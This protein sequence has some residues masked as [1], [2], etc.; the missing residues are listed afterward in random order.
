MTFN[1]KITKKVKDTLRNLIR[2]EFSSIIREDQSY[3]GWTNYDTW[4]VSMYLNNEQSLY[5]SLQK[6]RGH[7]T[8]DGLKRLFEQ[9]RKLNSEGYK[10]VDKHKVNWQ[11]IADS[12]NNQK[13]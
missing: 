11:E 5:K 7:I 10:E 4:A 12:E 9:L 1:D 3:E 6:F 8:V 2:E 13:D